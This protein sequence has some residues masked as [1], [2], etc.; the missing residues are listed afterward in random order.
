MEQALN[1]LRTIFID[2]L[3]RCE[4][5]H[6]EPF[7]CQECEYDKAR[8]LSAITDLLSALEIEPERKFWALLYHALI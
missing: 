8:L 4:H 2:I 1:E 5:C 6:G 7:W 3:N